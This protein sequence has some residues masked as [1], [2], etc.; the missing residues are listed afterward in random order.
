MPRP[1]AEGLRA[2]KQAILDDSG[3]IPALEGRCQ[4]DAVIRPHPSEHHG[5]YHELAARCSRVRWRI[6]ATCCPGCWPAALVH[7]N[8]CTTA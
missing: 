3:E 4:A 1:F 7:T 6:K 8:G 5:A 2:H